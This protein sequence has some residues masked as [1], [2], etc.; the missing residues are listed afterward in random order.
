MEFALPSDRRERARSERPQHRAA[1]LMHRSNLALSGKG[2]KPSGSARRVRVSVRFKSA[3]SAGLCGPNGF[4][5]ESVHNRQS[6]LR[7][8]RFL[9]RGFV[10]A[11]GQDAIGQEEPRQ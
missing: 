6:A 8:A 10:F 1:R 3:R 2:D 9:A 11:I 7:E 4:A 5:S